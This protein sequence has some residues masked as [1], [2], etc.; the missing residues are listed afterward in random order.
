MFITHTEASTTTLA[1]EDLLNWLYTHYKETLPKIREYQH[2]Q[3]EHLADSLEITQWAYER[4]LIEGFNGYLRPKDAVTRIEGLTILNRAFQ[5]EHYTYPTKKIPFMDVK[6]SYWGHRIINSAWSFEILDHALQFYPTDYLDSATWLV[7]QANVS[8]RQNS[9][10]QAAKIYD[11]Q[12]TGYASG[13]PFLWH[14]QPTEPED[15]HWVGVDGDRVVAEFVK[16]NGQQILDYQIGWTLDTL[17]KQLGNNEITLSVKQSN[18]YN[19][20]RVPNGTQVIFVAFL[21]NNVYTFFIDSLGENKVNAILR[22]E[23]SYFQNKPYFISS[24]EKLRSS[25]EYLQGKLIQQSRAEMGL[26]LYTDTTEQHRIIARA[27]SEDMINRQYFDHTTPDGVT[28]VKRYGTAI[29]LPLHLIGENIAA[30]QETVIHAHEALLNSLG[31]RKAILHPDL[32]H[33]FNGAAF[34]TRH[35]PYLTTVFYSLRE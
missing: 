19:V 25:Y 21:D 16:G 8:K 24:D 2:F 28:P 1:R 32:T 20:S 17:K 26:P 27:H 18:M 4:G 29:S 31:H 33:F 14:I 10:T 35:E 15:L 11:A 3:D 22:M 30:S 9:Y 7:W 34:N 12:L 23:E 5:W 13:Y 6:D